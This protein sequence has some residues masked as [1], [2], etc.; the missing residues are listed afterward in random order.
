MPKS[1]KVVSV[2]GIKELS[3][4]LA[5]DVAGI[6]KAMTS[7]LYTAG[8]DVQ[9]RAKELVPVDTG[10][11]KSTAETTV[12]K[13]AASDRVRIEVSFGGPTKAS[14]KGANYA[15]VQH[16][17]LDFAHPGGGQA[18]Y[19]E[20]PFVEEISTW[21]AGLVRRVREEFHFQGKVT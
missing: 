12:P 8:I 6:R 21:P 13:S 15:L 19:L 5:K 4:A 1:Q 2:S 10:N 3:D 11:L 17:R 9:N 18:K 16:E 20:Q 14:A 7:A